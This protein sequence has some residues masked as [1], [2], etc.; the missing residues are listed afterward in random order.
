[1]LS[2]PGRATQCLT[3]AL[4]VGTIPG[5]C[6]VPSRSFPHFLLPRRSSPQPGL[7]LLASTPLRPDR[8]SPGKQR[9]VDSAGKPKPW[10]SARLPWFLCLRTF[11]SRNWSAQAFTCTGR[12]LAYHGAPILMLSPPTALR[13][14]N[15]PQVRHLSMQQAHRPTRTPI[16]INQRSPHPVALRR[17]VSSQDVL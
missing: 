15:S 16:H 11:K 4:E 1:M 17:R 7:S 9:T 3:G 10:Q 5:A 14:P 13:N 6:H 2:R 8:G 12:S